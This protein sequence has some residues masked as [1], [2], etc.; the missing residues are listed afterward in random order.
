MFIQSLLA[1]N[2]L[3]HVVLGAYILRIL[4]RGVGVKADWQHAGLLTLAVVVGMQL[5]TRGLQ[6]FGTP[7]RIVLAV[8]AVWA[9]AGS[10]WLVSFTYHLRSKKLYLVGG[11]WGVALLVISFLI[12]VLDRII[13]FGL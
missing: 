3:I 1:L 11:M 7:N 6:I 12:S 9:F 8:V 13:L 2:I 4:L 10:G 5:I